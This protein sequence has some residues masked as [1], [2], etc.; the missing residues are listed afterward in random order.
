MTALTDNN[1]ENRLLNLAHEAWQ[2]IAPVDRPPRVDAALLESAYRHSAAL[3]AEH[4]RSFYMASSLLDS[5]ARQ[6]VRALYAFCRT[7]DDIVDEMNDEAAQLLEAWRERALDWHPPEHDLVAVA[8]AD[9][10][11]KYRLPQRLPEQLLDGVARDLDRV[12]YRT[13]DELATYCYG[14]ASTVGLMSMYI[15]G[16]EDEDAIGHAVKLGVALQLTNILRDVSEDWRRGRLYLPTEELQA[17]G[18]SEQD[19][20]NGEVDDRWRAFMRFQIARTKALYE[21]S[22]PGI[23][24]LAPQGRLAVSAAATFYGAILD[25]IE[26]HDY[27]VFSRRAYVNTWGKVRRLP[28]VWWRSKRP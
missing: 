27:D 17:Y 19:V 25:D 23:A 1:W 3:T 4:S 18:L 16:Y 2:A 20:A 9:T 6:A 26:G 15:I 11:A 5:P 10:R 14:V 7:A 13:F 21:G 8:W 22:R 24:L 28:K 12:R